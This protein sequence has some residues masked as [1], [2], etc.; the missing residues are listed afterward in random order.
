MF[1][2]LD[3]NK[4]NWANLIS[5]IKQIDYTVIDPTSSTTCQIEKVQ[6]S[7]TKFITGMRDC[8]YSD[9]L[10][11]KVILSAEETKTLLYN[12]C[13]ENNSGFGTKI[14]KTHSMHPF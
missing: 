6:H 7:F 1:K 4:A 13:L 9:R 12:L 8:A 11:V 10:S 14:F 5:A 3:F 2:K